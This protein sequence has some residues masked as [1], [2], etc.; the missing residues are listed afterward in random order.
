M[1][2][3]NG[4]LFRNKTNESYTNNMNE[5]QNSY[6]AVKESNQEHIMYDFI[7]INSEKVTSDF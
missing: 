3:Y 1:Y 5:Y 7:Y 6:A 2:L 4:I